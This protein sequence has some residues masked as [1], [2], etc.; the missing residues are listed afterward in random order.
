MSRAEWILFIGLTSLLLLMG[1][2][3]TSQL[4]SLPRNT[5]PEAS[6]QLQRKV[7]NMEQWSIDNDSAIDD[8]QWLVKNDRQR[9]AYLS[10]RIDVLT[11][12]QVKLQQQVARL[13]GWHEGR[14][15]K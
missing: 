14:G 1:V 11:Q 15:S 6:A 12:Q 7:Y 9:L 2:L 3:M 5:A 13:Q 10:D 8:L 4:M